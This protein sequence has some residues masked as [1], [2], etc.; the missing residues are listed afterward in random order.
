MKRKNLR[1]QT[2]RLLLGLTQQ[3]I[4][5]ILNVSRSHLSHHE[6]H[7]RHLSSGAGLRLSEMILYMLSPEAKA[8]KTLDKPQYEDGKTKSI[9]EKRLKGNEYQLRVLT[10]KIET[11]Q[12]KFE[13]CKK[14]A[15][16]MS[17]LNLPEEVEKAAK[18]EVLP[19]IESVAIINFRKTKSQLSLLQ[20]DQDL[21]QL[22][23][24]YLQKTLRELK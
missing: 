15:Q 3:E 5:M 11:A 24:E 20:I 10:R 22:Q 9:L 14:A 16:L 19:L 6:G 13:K 12:E 8:F 21:L 17:F 4:A 1:A 23:Q 2:D 18:P 7:R